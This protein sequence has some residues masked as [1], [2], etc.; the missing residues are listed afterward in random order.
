MPWDPGFYFIFCDFSVSVSLIVDANSLDTNKT[1]PDKGLR[2]Q[3]NN[4]GPFPA[5]PHHEIIEGHVYLFW[6]MH[7]IEYF[8]FG[9]LQFKRKRKEKRFVSQSQV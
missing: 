1:K 4:K 2:F 6:I 9:S 8:L 7:C 3:C 5:H